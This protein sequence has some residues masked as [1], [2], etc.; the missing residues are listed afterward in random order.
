MSQSAFKEV[1][2]FNILFKVVSLVFSLHRLAIVFFM[3]EELSV[4]LFPVAFQ[5]EMVSNP[6]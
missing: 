6:L 1:G 5:G 3:I 2:F 4:D